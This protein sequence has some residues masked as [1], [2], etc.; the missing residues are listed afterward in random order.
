[1]IIISMKYKD[2]VNWCNKRH[3][4]GCWS[5][6]EEMTCINIMEELNKLPF[7]KRE[8]IWRKKYRNDVVF[9]IVNPYV[10]EILEKMKE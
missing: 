8:R 5:S 1:M 10:K 9:R 3:S 6:F 4:D 7:W 2:F